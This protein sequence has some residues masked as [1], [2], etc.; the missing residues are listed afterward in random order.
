MI[1]LTIKTLDSQNHKFRVPDTF[2]ILELK[3]YI[4]AQV[5][6]AVVQQRLIFCGRVLSNETKLADIGIDGKV[7]HLV[8][9]VPRLSTTTS[10]SSSSTTTSTNSRS[11]QNTGP[12]FRGWHAHDPTVLFGAIGIP[13]E[14]MNNGE[15]PR[16]VIHNRY[17]GTGNRLQLA[18]D[19]IRRG[20]EV[21]NRLEN[22]RSN[23][24]SSS[25]NARQFPEGSQQAETTS[26]SVPPEAAGTPESSQAESSAPQSQTDSD[27]VNV[28]YE[29]DETFP[30][31]VVVTI[32]ATHH[33]RMPPGL[34]R[35]VHNHMQAN[36]LFPPSQNAPELSG[37]DD[38]VNVTPVTTPVGLSTNQSSSEQATGTL[39]S[40]ASS[41]QN[42]RNNT[43]SW[44]QRPSTITN[45]R[46]RMK[47]LIEQLN[48][49]NERLKPFYAMYCEYI[50]DDPQFETTE[51]EH[52]MLRAQ[53][54]FNGVSE[55]LH[56]ISHVYHAIS[57]LRVAFNRP[58]PRALQTRPCLVQGTIL[59][60]AHS[61]TTTT[62]A[63]PS[64]QQPTSTQTT[65]TSQSI[66]SVQAYR[67]DYAT[68]RGTHITIPQP[69]ETNTNMSVDPSTESNNTTSEFPSEAPPQ[70]VELMFDLAP[71]SIRIDSVEAAFINPTAP[72]ETG[73]TPVAVSQPILSANPAM[74]IDWMD[75]M[76]DVISSGVRR[77]FMSEQSLD[78]NSIPTTSTRTPRVTPR[79]TDSSSTTN[80]P[81][82]GLSRGRWDVTPRM[83]PFLPCSSHHFESNFRPMVL[84]RRSTQG[85]DR[86][87]S[88]ATSGNSTTDTSS[89]TSPNE[90]RSFPSRR[91]GRSRTR[92]LPDPEAIISG[93]HPILTWGRHRN[94]TATTSASNNSQATTQGS[95][96]TDALAGQIRAGMENVFD[97]LEREVDL[98]RTR[99]NVPPA[100]SSVLGFENPVSTSTTSQ[101]TA[102]LPNQLLLTPIGDIPYFS[103]LEGQSVLV[104]LF[105]MVA[106]NWTLR[107]MLSV[108]H[109]SRNSTLR[110]NPVTN[111]SEQI[112]DFIL[113]RIMLNQPPNNQNIEDAAH[114][115]YLEM[116]PY[117]NIVHCTVP[118]RANINVNASFRRCILQNLRGIVIYCSENR[119]GAINDIV[120]TLSIFA[121]GFLSLIV[122]CCDSRPIFR[123]CVSAV[124]QYLPLPPNLHHLIMDE[125]RANI[126]RYWERMTTFDM[127][128]LSV[129]DYVV[130]FDENAPILREGNGEQS[131]N[132]SIPSEIIN[133]PLPEVVI[134]SQD[135]HHNVP[136]EWVPVITR[137][138]QR[139][140]RQGTQPPYSDAY[141]SGMPN[142]RRKIVTSSKPQGSLSQII[143][144]NL[145]VAMGAAGV[146]INTEVITSAGADTA[147]QNAYTE[148]IRTFG[149][150]GLDTHPDFCPTRYPNASKFFYD[151][152]HPN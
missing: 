111:H 148:R 33:M 126:D 80:S 105:L 103:S 19:M 146:A 134:G 65:T 10:G 5:N 144:K 69:T 50:N 115:I 152:N 1:D 35:Q 108:N 2:T 131:S 25:S 12:G 4:A 117:I 21:L 112:V 88:S 98:D 89:P 85:T 55:V 6:V 94:N 24:Q 141:L 118:T 91:P 135:W 139:Q 54:I 99:V 57:D 43:E 124:V 66:P 48:K 100:S 64:T 27:S 133:E 138:S 67:V 38:I 78:W 56:L 73:G 145:E 46:R 60:A 87:T 119:S 71:G 3:E 42:S 116:M 125:I 81:S 97:T 132:P 143:A 17:H 93:I 14:L 36:N 104:D 11:G 37:E 39:P 61:V 114:R 120:P 127:M 147:V 8:Q 23:R 72:A 84:A 31:T 136:S 59:H 79:T 123:L 106:R 101:S 34:M 140:R 62:A 16:G 107:D 26:T 74:P 109:V 70:G 41:E 15:F 53:H 47:D 45:D 149:R 121:E 75:Q 110:N 76:I 128:S 83:D 58:P 150:S 63:P 49:L 95:S 40:S 9:K 142:K 52:G 86:S 28:S 82:Q 13:T 96:L 29:V 90:G 30:N 7:M 137:D 129:V 44:E 102:R 18:L 113:N 32:D 77:P 22:P 51:G 122:Y 20:N 151:H 68:G 130:P 92:Y